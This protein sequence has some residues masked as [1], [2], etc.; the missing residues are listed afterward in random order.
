MAVLNEANQLEDRRQPTTTL[1]GWRRFVE[2]D[3]PE[4]EI[5]PDGDWKSLSEND[6][7]AYDEA[8]IAH[9]AELVVVT[10]SAIEEVTNEGRLLTLINQRENGARQGLIVSGGAATGKTTALKQLGRLHELRTRRRF[11]KSDR[12]PVVYVTAPP[13]GS[14]RKLAMEFA[15]FLGLPVSARKNATDIA[16]AVCQ[17]L[18]D[19]RCD[20]V[21][22][23]ELHNINMA[24][25]V[26]EDHSDHMKYF[27]E[28]L[29][30][31]FVYAGIEVERSGIFTGVRGKQLAGRCSLI[32]TAPFPYHDEWKQLVAGMETTLRL[33][34][35][36][37]GA[38]VAQAK[39]L[40]QRTGGMIG[41]L[42]R[43]V[44]ASSTMAILNESEAV[45]RELLDTIR[46]DHAAE[47]AVRR[48]SSGR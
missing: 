12:I 41:S 36:E 31:T 48:A 33:H 1:E 2:S 47:S 11:P 27:T 38:L 13:K 10:T 8:R 18:I 43:L 37:P 46:T 4:F 7:I 26:G 35:H 28:H 29:P 21:I 14:P 16:D 5:L 45:T 39:Y 23:D 32:N 44:R 3:P 30:A 25:S 34:R 15:R 40:H 6:R 42:A 24:T 20:I 19:A 22:V 9:H 17:I